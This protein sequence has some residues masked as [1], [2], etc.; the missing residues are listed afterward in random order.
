MAIMQQRLEPLIAT[1]VPRE[2]WADLERALWKVTESAQ[3]LD[4]WNAIRQALESAKL[5]IT[6]TSSFA[7]LYACLLIATRDPV[8]IEALTANLPTDANP[9]LHLARGWCYNRQHQP[10]LALTHLEQAAQR[11]TGRYQGMAYLF[12]GQTL[13]ALRQ[14]WEA[15]FD[16]AAQHLNGRNLGLCMLER[17]TCLDRLG[18]G[19]EARSLWLAAVPLLKRD[20]FYSA[21]LQYNLGISALRDLDT[22]AERH[23]LELQRL[24]KSHHQWFVQAWRGLAAIRRVLGE[25]TRAELAYRIALEATLEPDQQADTVAGLSMTLRF[26]QKPFEAL[27]VIQT[28]LASF[29]TP[30]P[31]LVLHQAATQLM[32]GLDKQ[33][34]TNLDSLPTNLIAD[35][36]QRKTIFLAELERRS[37]NAN[38]ALAYLKTINLKSLSAREELTHLPLLSQLLEIMLNRPEPLEYENQRQVSVFALGGLRVFVNQRVVSFT[39][40]TGELLALLLERGGKASR[41]D[42]CSTLF[43]GLPLKRALSGLRTLLVELRQVLGWQNAYIRDGA[44]IYLDPEVSWFYDLP[45][46]RKSKIVT[47]L[48]LDGI[49]REWV[50]EIQQELAQLSLPDMRNLN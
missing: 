33:A 34:K 42:L 39:P 46:A 27:E 30:P 18:R 20:G 1:L 17:G 11:L 13:F 7:P 2:R 35:D 3:S 4:D 47:G 50:L 45:E 25:F 40:R 19:L 49:Y 28:A 12:M 36:M 37:Q 38:Q 10:I 29:Q 16:Q 24:A 8:A 44:V 15:A 26:A 31:I 21:W 6:A 22:N 14:D 48:F 9:M 5:T 43:T 23:F 41:E 32:L